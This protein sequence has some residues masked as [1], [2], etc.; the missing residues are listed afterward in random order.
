MYYYKAR[1]YSP[2]L[3]RFLQTDPIGYEDQVNLYAYVGNDPVNVLDTTGES[4]RP[5]QTR[6]VAPQ[7]AR[8]L[9]A[10]QAALNRLQTA[11]PAFRDRGSIQRPGSASAPANDAQFYRQAF[12]ARDVSGYFGRDPVGQS[13]SGAAVSRLVSSSQPQATANTISRGGVNS[14]QRVIKGGNVQDTFNSIVG[15]GSSRP[16]ANGGRVATDVNLGNGV[17]A[18]VTLYPRTTTGRDGLR[19]FYRDIYNQPLFNLKFDFL[20]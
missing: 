19:I 12:A 8:Q 1:I 20:P 14:Y 2:T 13:A 18:N 16:L 5:A 17:R 9:Q 6:L 15:S 3:G 4:R 11:D 7:T 10:A